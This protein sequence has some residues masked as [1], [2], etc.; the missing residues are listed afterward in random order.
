M[1]SKGIIALALAALLLSIS[2]PSA[3]A[4]NDSSFI[5]ANPHVDGDIDEICGNPSNN[6]NE[7]N[8]LKYVWLNGAII[9][10][11][12]N[13]DGVFFFAVLEPGGQSDPNDGSEKNLSDDHD[14]YT[15]RSFTIAEGQISG[16]EGNHWL[17]SGVNESENGDPKPNWSLPYIR[18]YPF[19]ATSNP[20]REY[21]LAV[22]SLENGYPVDPSSCKYESFKAAGS[23]TESTAMLHGNVFEDMYA[24]G[25][26]GAG[27]L[28]I[29]NQ[30]V[31]L[32]GIGLDGKT[33]D[34]RIRTDK[35]GNWEFRSR[36][37]SL[38]GKQ[39][40]DIAD[41]TICSEID[42]GW[43]Q[44]FP[45][46]DG[47]HHIIFSTLAFESISTYDFGRWR[48]VAVT[49]CKERRNNKEGW[50]S[51]RFSGHRLQRLLHMDGPDPRIY[52]WR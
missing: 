38:P 17:D 10:H 43:T 52:L 37:L 35:D 18:L 34:A 30:K 25:A 22:C 51:D 33:I 23:D 1:K 14:F 8:D 21:I 27:D 29:K 3:T 6:C 15:N 48:R 47:C 44:S 41:L 24:D 20:G 31:F 19:T 26:K 7:F 11:G 28:G 49:A 39:T 46:G 32:T 2:N 42:T 16:Y 36:D 5:T 13:Q 9:G 50:H 4:V 40:L 45:E 12:L